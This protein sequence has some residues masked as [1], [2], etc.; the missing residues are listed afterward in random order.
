MHRTWWQNVE[1]LLG[2]VLVLICYFSNLF[3][4]I[5]L[6]YV[7]LFRQLFLLVLDAV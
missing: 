6:V 5:V 3:L 1:V 7:L 4:I 2:M